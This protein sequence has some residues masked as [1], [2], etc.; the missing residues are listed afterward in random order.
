MAT[1]TGKKVA[2][3]TENGF[4]ELELT[5]P[6]EAVE[7]AGGIAH[8]VSPQKDKVRSWDFTTWGPDYKVDVLLENADPSDYDALILPGGQI[9]PD[10]LRVNPK[11]LAFIK[12]FIEADKPIGAICHAAWPLTELDYVRGKKMTSYQ[13]ISTDMKNAGANW[14]DEEV[15]V[16]GK[17]VTSRYPDDL[18]AFNETIVEVIAKG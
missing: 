14:V 7:A 9:N 15:V 10:L 13:S 4:E 6:K 8:I 18:K 11:V 1:L 5:K 16:D 2:L 12:H 17:F 3:L